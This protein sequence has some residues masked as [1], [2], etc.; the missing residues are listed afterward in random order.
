MVRSGQNFALGDIRYVITYAKFGDDQLRGFSV[1]MVQILGFSM[2]SPSSLLNTLA[3]P[4]DVRC[5][6][7]Q[8]VRILH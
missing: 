3:L 1:A 8:S 2:L 6:P 4:C 5:R 7:I